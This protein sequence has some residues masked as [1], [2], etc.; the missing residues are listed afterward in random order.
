MLRTQSVNLIR[1]HTKSNIFKYGRNVSSANLPAEADVVIIGGGT[2][3]CNVFYAL[4]K[5]GIKAV[6]L[7]QAK[8]TSGTTWHT[9]GLHWR[10]RPN[11]V[12]IQLLASTKKLLESLESETGLDP[13]Y[14]Q[15]GGIFIARSEERIQ[16][17]LRLHTLG[18]F[19]KIESQMLSPRETV[20]LSPILD[21]KNFSAALYSPGDGVI[22]PTM[23]CSAL[24]KGA[25]NKGGIHFENC[26]VTNL[27]L[28]R[29]GGIKKIVGVETASHG[30]I[31]TKC[32]VNACGVW[33]RNIAHMA[34]V[35]IPLQP[36][37]HAYIVTESIPAVKGTPNIRD[38]DASVY[39][40]IQGDKIYMGGYEPN[41]ELLKD[42]A[43]D[44]HFGL[45]ELDHSVFEVHMQQATELCPE[46]EKAGIK[47]TICGPESFT[48]DHKPLMGEDPRC[49]GLY[50]ACG[51][52]SAGMMLSGGCAEQLAEW[53]IGGRPA[54][55]MFNYDIR[56]F[57]PSMRTN[58]A[59]I[60]ETSHES[61]LKNYSIV[62]PHDQFMSGRDVKI[63]V[64][65]EAQIANGAVMEQAQ[66]WERPGYFIKESTAPVRD[67]DWYGQ[68]DHSVNEDQR[69]ANQIKKDHTFGFSK[70]HELIGEEALACR[71][72]CAL[73]NLS[74]F[75]KCYLTGPDA[76]EAADWLFTANTDKEP[77]KV[78]Y[79]CSLNSKG[80]VEADLTVTP[81]K[82]GVGKLVGP[83]L[84]GR[85]Y[86]IVAG[87]ASGYHTISNLRKQLFLKKYRAIVTDV[88]DELAIL[89]IQGPKSGEFLQSITE[90]PIT[91]ER[92]PM[93]QSHLV[94]INGHTCRAMRISFVGELGYE[95]H[96][97]VASSIPIYNKVVD[98]GRSFDMK[99]AGFRALYSLSCEKGYHLWNSDLRSNDNP[100]EAGLG[101]ICRKNGIYQGKDKIDEMKAKGVSKKRIFLTVPDKNV[102]IYGLETIWRDDQVVGFLRRGEYAYSLDCSVGIGFV[103]HPEKKILTD[104]FITSGNYEIEVMGK[105][106]PA[107]IHLKSIFDPKNLRLQGHYDTNFVEQSHFDD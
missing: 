85:G 31:R 42:V 106:Y 30:T 6:L 34:G 103:E 55:P 2:I 17:Y 73:F 67:Y 3:G 94:T 24:V 14:I 27:I 59:W 41:P 92:F 36:M 16:E 75:A 12:E 54:L 1:K 33:S 101:F 19:F 43:N 10:L 65:H 100:V 90:T 15:N 23:Y 22:D 64:F 98:I 38:H 44:F 5:R 79:T 53:V 40:R 49:Y 89:S 57:L 70:N 97:P 88:T 83:I 52:N 82:E 71:N 37:K 39:F 47:T 51:F 104:E 46:L 80:G 91:D 60:A 62:F 68:Y 50:H 32:V 78:V 29:P 84:K 9:A 13:G 105:R 86:Y 95:L 69:Y 20:H 77:E 87:G 11:D 63:D 102:A 61:Y 96:I 58:K 7:E 74:Y 8:V 35:E 81:L 48:P 56:R 28:D 99:H 93:F 21:P 72:Q 4:S 45:Y 76:Q 26:P 66:G 18:H 25:T 107:N